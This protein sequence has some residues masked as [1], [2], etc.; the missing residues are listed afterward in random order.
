MSKIHFPEHLRVFYEFVEGEKFEK[1]RDY[2]RQHLDEITGW[3]VK[4]FKEY[5]LSCPEKTEFHRKFN[6]SFPKRE[7]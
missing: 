3:E 6:S 1:A 4:H 2:L 5:C 7:R